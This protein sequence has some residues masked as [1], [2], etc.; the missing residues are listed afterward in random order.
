MCFTERMLHNENLV[1]HQEP[2]PDYSIR[3]FRGGGEYGPAV[4]VYW[5]D[6]LNEFA[7]LFYYLVLI[8]CPGRNIL[9]NTGMPPDFSDFEKFVQGWH[10][11]CRL[12]RSDDERPQRVLDRAG[13]TPAQVDTVI[14]TP[15]TVYTT[16]NVSLF[17][18]ARFAVSRRGWVD[19][20][21]PERYAPKL[22]PD[23]A[24]PVES[25]TYLAGEALSRVQLLDDEDTICPGIRCFWTGGH[26]ASS[27]AVC[28][29]TAKGTAILGDCFFTYD[30]IEKNIPIGWAENMHEINAAYDRVRR[31]ADIIVPL[32]D[33][34]V[35]RRFPDGKI[36]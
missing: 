15:L 35:L 29:A 5:N 2:C 7:E 3:V 19:F 13:I 30:N 11:S 17:P 31:E 33:P 34:E 36:A 26:H 9:I 8:Q 4:S 28:V 23:I 21:A 20:W 10:A 16:G 24:I 6:R 1:A 18:N 32:Y 25:R 22:P 12:F 14:L 27:L